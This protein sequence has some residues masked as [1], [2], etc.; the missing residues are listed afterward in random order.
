[1]SHKVEVERPD[2]EGLVGM[3]I[4]FAFGAAGGFSLA[5]GVVVGYATDPLIGILVGIGTAVGVFCGL[6]L[7]ALTGD[8]IADQV[9]KAISGKTNSTQ[10]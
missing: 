2:K 10:N 1:M 7:I 3:Q 4:G 5:I 8:A 9:E 6:V